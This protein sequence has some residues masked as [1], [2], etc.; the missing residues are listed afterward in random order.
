MSRIKD[1]ATSERDLSREA[2]EEACTHYKIMPKFDPVASIGLTSSEVRKRWPR[3]AGTCP[4]CGRGG[5]F[6]ASYMHYLAGDW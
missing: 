5:I 1:F 4:D 6:Y 2:R 3:G